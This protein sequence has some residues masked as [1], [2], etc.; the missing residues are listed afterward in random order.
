FRVLRHAGRR[1]SCPLPVASPAGAGAA[2]FSRMSA[3]TRDTAAQAP[4][5]DWLQERRAAALERFDDSGLPSEAEEIWRYSRISELDLDLYTPVAGDGQAGIPD[6]VRPAVEAVGPHAG[7]IVTRNGSIVHTGLDPDLS[8]R[9]VEAG[10]VLRAADA[11]DLLGSVA[12]TSTD[13][14]TELATA[15]VT[16]GALVRVPAGVVVDRP[17]VVVHWVDADGGAVFPR[18][19][20]V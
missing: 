4:G 3:F 17:I 15:F 20:V 19:V 8:A 7:L 13:A 14:F 11:G 5:P 2:P 9:G 6:E 16:G 1:A 12:A 18:T 10:D